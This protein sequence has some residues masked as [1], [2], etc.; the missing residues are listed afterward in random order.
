MSTSAQQDESAV[1]AA[2]AAL[3]ADFGRSDRDAYFSHFAPSASFIFYPEAERLTSRA[4]YEQDRDLL[5]ADRDPIHPARIYGDLLPRLTP[6]MLGDEAA[7][8]AH[9]VTT[10]VSA[11]GQED[12]VNERET[13]VFQFID[14][15][16]LA[17]HEHLSP[18]PATT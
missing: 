1:L 12:T 16:W 4:A 13:I 11:G 17:V 7:V 5:R 15:R 8:F 18:A 2:A 3:V 9:D 6:Q 10:V 14:G